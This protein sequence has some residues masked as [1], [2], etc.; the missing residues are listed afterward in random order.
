MLKIVQPHTDF[1]AKLKQLM[2]EHPI[3]KPHQMGMSINWSEEVL[4][5]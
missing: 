2:Q 4:W 5:Q 3:A 1:P